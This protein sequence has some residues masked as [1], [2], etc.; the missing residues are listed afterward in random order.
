MGG[1]QRE[2]T[3]VVAVNPEVLETVGDLVSLLVQHNPTRPIKFN[4]I[5]ILTNHF[6]IGLDEE[7]TTSSIPIDSL[8][9]ERGGRHEGVLGRGV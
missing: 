8:T 2:H 9:E 1:V 4:L 6:R 5:L 7:A 3:L